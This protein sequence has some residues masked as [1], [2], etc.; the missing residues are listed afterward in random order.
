MEAKQQ[1]P[2]ECKEGP[3]A[4]MSDLHD[5]LSLDG[6]SKCADCDAPGPTWASVNNAVFIC[7]QCSGVHRSLGVEI[8]FVQSTKLDN[9]D[10]A[11]VLMMK[12]GIS[13]EF[14]NNTLLEFSVPPSHRKPNH[15]SQRDLREAYIRA[16]YIDRQFLP[17][18]GK[19]K[20]P[21][22]SAISEG[23]TLRTESVGEIEFV[24]IFII[25]FVSAKNL[26][27]ADTLGLS[28]PYG[29][30][31]LGGQQM[32]TKTISNNLNPIFNE[33]LMLSW[34][35]KDPLLIELW[36]EDNFNDDGK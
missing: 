6:N 8:S 15:T 18:A 20:M 12:N 30:L 14:V 25:K 3:R 28:D 34:D 2:T 29:V 1:F 22:V 24:G 31:K 21:P 36:D 32:R 26:V 16:K 9:W 27:N 35:G 17:G 7:T 23:E 5:L 11:N 33:K 13:N 10:A 19:E 4:P